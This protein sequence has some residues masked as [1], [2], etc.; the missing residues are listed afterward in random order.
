[1]LTPNLRYRTPSFIVAGPGRTGSTL[2]S[3]Y[4][5]RILKLIDHPNQFVLQTHDFRLQLDPSIPV[6][7]VKRKDLFA[8]TL[9]GVIADHYNEWTEYTNKDGTFVA[10]GSIF[11]NKYVWN[12]RWFEAFDHF[13]AYQSTTEIFF[14]D[15]IVD[16]TLISKAAGLPDHD[17]PVETEKSPYRPERIENLDEIKDLF[18]RLENEAGIRNFPLDSGILG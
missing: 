5:E 8:H 6:I 1:M 13:T 2:V 17:I 16:P 4:I 7:L 12:L 10:D 18:H 11:K 9:S 15:F 14:E 3:T